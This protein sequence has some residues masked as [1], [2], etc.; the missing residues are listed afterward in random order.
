[1]PCQDCISIGIP[2][3]LCQDG[4]GEYVV[5]S[6]DY[7]YRRH[8]LNG[9]IDE[10]RKLPLST[11]GENLFKLFSDSYNLSSISEPE[12]VLFNDKKDEKG[13]HYLTSG[14]ISINVGQIEEQ[15]FKYILQGKEVVCTFK[16]HHDPM[17]CNYSH[18]EMK[19]Y[20]DDVQFSGR[21]AKSAKEFFRRRLLEAMSEI[22]RAS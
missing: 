19:Y 6:E 17:E 21:P 7:I 5:K 12:D 11:I 2:D 20:M 22:K 16:V 8:D 3:R 14:I 13:G 10:I 1:M 9:S 15:K 4:K 18:A